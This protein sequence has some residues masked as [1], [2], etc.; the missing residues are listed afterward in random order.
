[1]CVQLLSVRHVALSGF[2]YTVSHTESGAA[3][4]LIAGCSLG[5]LCAAVEIGES[6]FHFTK[7]AASVVCLFCKQCPVQ[8]SPVPPED[9]GQL[10]AVG[11]L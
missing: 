9:L 10:D 8:H 11:E 1:M 3:G 2:V 7:S 5:T 6:A 4:Q